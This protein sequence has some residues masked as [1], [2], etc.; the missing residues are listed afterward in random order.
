MCSTFIRVLFFFLTFEEW[1]VW[2]VC[3]KFIL[4][5]LHAGMQLFMLSLCIFVFFLSPSLIIYNFIYMLSNCFSQSN[6]SPLA[7]HSLLSVIPC[8]LS[9][10]PSSFFKQPVAICCHFYKDNFKFLFTNLFLKAWYVNIEHVLLRSIPS[11]DSIH[12]LS[13]YLLLL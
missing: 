7:W 3:G 13:R 12:S 11:P 6:S 10:S 5:W 1:L 2:N 8:V 9:H 4:F